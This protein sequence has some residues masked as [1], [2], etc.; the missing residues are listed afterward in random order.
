L[1]AFFDDAKAASL[2][3]DDIEGDE[4]S[5]EVYEKKRLTWSQTPLPSGEFD[6]SLVALEI[7]AD[8]PHGFQSYYSRFR[9][10]TQQM[11]N[12]TMCRYTDE[13]FIAARYREDP[14]KIGGELYDAD[15]IIA[16]DDSN[17][18]GSIREQRHG[19][20]YL[21]L[22]GE[23]ASGCFTREQAQRGGINKKGQYDLRVFRKA[24]GAN[25]PTCVIGKSRFWI[26]SQFRSIG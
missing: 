10:L 22:A 18:R 14:L 21:R 26:S 13:D 4:E 1:I 17:V 25:S 15:L 6:L 8:I 3:I 2:I 20:W 16:H 7:G 9:T 5:E 24:A 19:V 11:R 12:K 23:C